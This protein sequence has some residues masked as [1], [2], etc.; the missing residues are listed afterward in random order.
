MRFRKRPV[1][2]DGFTVFQNTSLRSLWECFCYIGL[3][4]E[5]YGFLMRLNDRALIDAV[6]LALGALIDS[7]SFLRRFSPWFDSELL[8]IGFSLGLDLSEQLQYIAS[9]AAGH[10]GK[11]PDKSSIHSQGS[12]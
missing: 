11:L 9:P 5:H 8:D 4:G 7:A 10:S 2:N 6:D 1:A 12:T 3:G